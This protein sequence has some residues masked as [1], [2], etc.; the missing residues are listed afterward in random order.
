MAA[1]FMPE[2]TGYRTAK[3]ED[4]EAGTEKGQLLLRLAIRDRTKKEPKQY[5]HKGNRIYKKFEMPMG[6]DSDEEEEEDD[7]F[8]GASFGDLVDVRILKM[9]SSNVIFEEAVDDAAAT[10]LLIEAGNENVVTVVE[11]KACIIN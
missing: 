5:D 7:G 10:Q 9:A 1:N 6:E 2:M 4:D 3:V 11:E 8:R